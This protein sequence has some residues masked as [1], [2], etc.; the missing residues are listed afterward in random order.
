M[1]ASII[2]V[3]VFAAGIAV[4]I[5]ENHHYSEFSPHPSTGTAYLYGK[6]QSVVDA[7]MMNE[8]EQILSTLLRYFPQGIP[9]EW[10]FQQM[11]TNPTFAAKLTQILMDVP[12]I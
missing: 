6:R 10:L 2:I 12:S 1:R 4:A 5:S 9:M 3:L 11:K 7:P 8:H